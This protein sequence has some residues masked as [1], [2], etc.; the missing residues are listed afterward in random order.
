V[1]IAYT[2]ATLAERWDCSQ[3]VIRKLIA[4]NRLACFRVGTLIRISVEEVRRFECQNIASNDSAAD[5]PS[6]IETTPESGTGNSFERPTALG[7][8][9]KHEGDGRRATVHH[10]P[11][12]GSSART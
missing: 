4:D 5:M 6:S 2:V 7:L 12:A 8:K 10:G 3:G 9:R 1:S 11:W